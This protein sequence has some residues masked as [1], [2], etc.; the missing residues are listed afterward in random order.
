MLDNGYRAMTNEN[1]AWLYN[2]KLK[3]LKQLNGSDV[4]LFGYMLPIEAASQHRHF[5][6]SNRN[7]S[8]PFCMPSSGGN[9]VEVYSKESLPYRS[10][11]FWLHGEFDVNKD[12]HSPLIYRLTNAYPSDKHE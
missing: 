8:C 6:F 2:D 9:L 10:E 7:H 1:D 3:Y 5:L 11:A 4:A 12:Q